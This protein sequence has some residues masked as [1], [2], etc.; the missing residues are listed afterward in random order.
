LYLDGGAAEARL[1]EGPMAS[2]WHTAA[3]SMRLRIVRAGSE[4]AWPKPTRPA[5]MLH[6]ESEI[7]ELRPSRCRPDR[8]VATV[9]SETCNRFNEVVQVLVAKPV[10]PQRMRPALRTAEWLR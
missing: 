3:I 10:V 2:G 1:F 9:R 5:A 6:V 7:L 4:S 8:G